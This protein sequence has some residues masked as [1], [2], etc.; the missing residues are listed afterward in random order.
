MRL[1]T[2]LSILLAFSS[3]FLSGQTDWRKIQ[4]VEDVCKAYPEKMQY[5]FGN[6]N[7]ETKGLEEVKQAYREGSLP[8]ACTLLLVYY[9][10]KTNEKILKGVNEA[11][12]YFF[13]KSKKNPAAKQLEQETRQTKIIN[14]ADSILQDIYTF[15]NV[16]GKVPRLADGHLKWAHNGPEDDIEW[17]WALN[18]HYS[19]NKLIST[20]PEFR[21]SPAW[22]DY[23]IQTMTAS[24]KDQVYPDGV[25]T[26]LTSSYHHVALSNFDLFADICRQN[27]TA[28]SDYYTKTLEAMWN[29]LALTMRPDG[30]GLLN[31]VADQN[32]NRLKIQEEAAAYKRPD[33]TWIASNDKVLVTEPVKG[34]WEIE[35]PFM[36][37]KNVKVNF[38]SKKLTGRTK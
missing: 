21:E 32:N 26:E 14:A 3:A 6:M 34:S 28:L 37:S 35:V 30:F 25:Q 31:N 4:T 33:W 2:I 24:M 17:A 9:K 38:D 7:L 11:S 20:W 19:T 36:N 23:A 5:I 12:D 27:K 10:N 16:T 8:K 29:Y 15:Q 22:M 18:R 13:Y 1:N